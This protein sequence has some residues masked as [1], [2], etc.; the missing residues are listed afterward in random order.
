MKKWITLAL[1]LAAAV[2]MYVF[3]QRPDALRV[4]AAQVS[5]GDVIASVTNTRAGT[6][7]ACRRAGIAPAAGGG[8][9]GL[10]VA[11]GDAVS[12]LQD[13]GWE[14]PDALEVCIG[15]SLVLLISM[16]WIGPKTRGSRF[17]AEGGTP[18]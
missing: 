5:R 1:I 9:V 14:L 15:C 10:C 18:G 2:A 7:D 8:I 13:S 12:A 4:G 16:L 6:V 11:D 3:S 17:L